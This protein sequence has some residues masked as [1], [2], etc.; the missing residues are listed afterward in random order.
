MFLLCCGIRGNK[1]FIKKIIKS[2]EIKLSEPARIPY[3][4]FSSHYCSFAFEHGLLPAGI[5]FIAFGEVAVWW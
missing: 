1:V 2:E 5:K 4:S 3:F